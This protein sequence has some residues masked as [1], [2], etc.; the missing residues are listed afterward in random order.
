MENLTPVERDV[1]C[2]ASDVVR[3]LEQIYL[4]LKSSAR[5]IPL[6]ETADAV[7]ALVSKGLLVAVA[8]G[9]G[10]TLSEDASFVWKDRFEPTEQGRETIVG[11]V[12]K[13]KGRVYRGV[14]KDL[15]TDVSFEDFQEARREISKNFPRE[16]PK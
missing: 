15:A 1:L 6:S 7:R 4:R 5:S 11:S 2:A 14:F 13:T 8:N 12:S 16:F 3:D 10:H 9:R